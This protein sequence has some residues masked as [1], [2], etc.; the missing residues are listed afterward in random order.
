MPE[1][2]LDE[3]WILAFESIHHVLAAERALLDRH[4]WCDLIPTPR[5]VRT[6]C[7]MVIELRRADWDAASTIVRTLARPPVAVCRRTAR[8]YERWNLDEPTA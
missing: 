7:G 4:V 6:D 5:D 3:R 1:P 8:G 2:E